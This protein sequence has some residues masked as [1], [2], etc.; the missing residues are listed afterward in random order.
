MAELKP[1]PFCKGQNINIIACYDDAC[2]E[3]CCERC[4]DKVTYA[5]VCNAHRGG[6]GASC[7]WRTTKEDAITAWN[8]R[9]PKRKENK[10]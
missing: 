9:T 3:A 1:C 8:T 5:V 4:C 2:D 7:G 10:K 6:C